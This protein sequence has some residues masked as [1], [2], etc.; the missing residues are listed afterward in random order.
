M[1]EWS[2]PAPSNLTATAVS[3]S[4]IDLQWQDNSF[5]EDGFELYRSTDGTN[6]QLLTTTNANTTSYFDTTVAG[7]LT[8][9]YRVRTYNTVGD[10]SDWSNVVM[11]FTFRYEWLPTW[12]TVVASDNDTFAL[13]TNGTL[14]AWGANAGQLGLGDAVNRSVPTLIASDFYYDVF[15]D[16]DSVATAETHTIARKTNGRL[17]AWGINGAGQLG[18]GDTLSTDSPFP[19]GTETDWFKIAVG[20]GFTVAHKTNNTLWAWGYNEYGQLGLGDTTNR[21]MPSQIGSDSDW[22]AVT[23]GYYHTVALKTNNTI[24]SWGM[25][26]YGQLGRGGNTTIPGQ[27]GTNSDWSKIAA[28]GDIIEG[29]TIAIK[30]NGTLWAWGANSVG[31]LGLGD[32]ETRTTPSVIGTDSDWSV[33]DAGQYHTIAL[34]TNGIIWSWGYNGKGQ[35]GLGDTDNRWTPSPIGSA[36]DWS[37]V[38]AGDFHTIGLKTDGTIWSWGYNISGQLGLGDTINRNIPYPLGSPATPSS[39]NTTVISSSR[40]DLSWTDNSFNEIGFKIER[41]TDG[42]PYTQI[43][44]V[45]QDVI[46]YQDKTVTPGNTY[47]YRVRSYNTYGDSPYSDGVTSAPSVPSNLNLT[48]ISS[49]QINLFW[50]DN[51]PDETGYKIERKFGTGGTYEQIGTTTIDVV[52]YSDTTV[53]PSNTY[54]YRVGAYN[55]FGNSPYSNEKEAVFSLPTAPSLLTLA[56]V[57]FTRIDLSWADNSSNESGFKIER[58]YGAP[59]A[60]VQL[61]TVGTNII[62]YSDTTVTPS[63]TYYYRV[64]AYNPL[65]DSPYSNEAYIATIPLRPLSEDTPPTGS[66]TYDWTAGYRF[67]P[68]VNGQI[69]ALG[70]YIDSGI[71]NITVILWDDTG[72][73]LGR[74]TVSSNPGWQWAN[75]PTPINVSA[76]TFYRVSVSCT[77]FWYDPFSMPTTRGNITISETCYAEDELDV[78]P[79][80]L[81][82]SNMY[83]WADIEFIAE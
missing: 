20:T 66:M 17:W 65:G 15:E 23:A 33:V 8:Y 16:I 79:I 2:L 52:T 67:S 40:I 77:T 29:C 83:G 41:R 9:Y 78:F 74:V 42:V 47:Y 50:K 54:Y 51:S 80:D 6:Y 11:E 12:S 69:I 38:V 55:D 82:T 10:R 59:G 75:L 31:Q 30:A 39:L 26:W 13:A 19:I 57:S 81:Y 43:G 76:G 72:T 14:W 18:T 58:S 4:Q 49:T 63:N 24:W 68:N 53:T 44:T 35:L 21:T 5:G 36:S 7:G 71:G 1:P 64:R 27:I 56:V 45:G 61:A 25:N 22:A 34:K 73:E 37:T 46:L 70:R 3:T 62:S 60:Y 48:V 32:W 28:G